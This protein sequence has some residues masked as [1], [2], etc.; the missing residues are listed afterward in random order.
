MVGRGGGE[1]EAV[2]S[3]SGLGPIA[4]AFLLAV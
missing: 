1:V 2:K 3:S 4:R